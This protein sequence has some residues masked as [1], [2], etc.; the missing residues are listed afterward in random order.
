MWFFYKNAW[1]KRMACMPLVFSLNSCFTNVTT[2]SLICLPESGGDS[3]N[4]REIY[5]TWKMVTGYTDGVRSEEELQ[6]DFDVLV[7]QTGGA[8]C[9]VSYVS[10]SPIETAFTGIYSQD[11]NANR[12]EITLIAPISVEVSATYSFAGGCSNPTMTLRYNNGAVE[13]YQFRSK[14]VGDGCPLE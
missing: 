1:F 8:L 14:D 5:G 13:K 12:L 11:V 4:V 3:I 9:R 2:D 7:V 6:N 10:Q